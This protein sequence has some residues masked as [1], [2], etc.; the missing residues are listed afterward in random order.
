M[1]AVITFGKIKPGKWDE[2]MDLYVESLQR[3]TMGLN[4]LVGRQLLRATDDSNEAV[5]ISY[6]NS[7]ESWDAWYTSKHHKG[8]SRKA[9]TYYTGEYQFKTFEVENTS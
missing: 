2:Y 6:W 7:K 8:L 9:E 5:S 3:T 4:G 1:F